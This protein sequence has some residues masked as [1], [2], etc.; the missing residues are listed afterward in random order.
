MDSYAT[1][2]FMV[3]SGIHFDAVS[4]HGRASLPVA[5]AIAIEPSVAALA[6]GLRAAGGFT[7]QNTMRLRCKSCGHIMVGDYEA[8][9]HAGTSGHKDFVQAN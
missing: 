5:D 2:G 4:C 7:D 8:R 3:F 9:L 6:S 1:R